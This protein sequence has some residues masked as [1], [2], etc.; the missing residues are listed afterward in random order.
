MSY[1]KDNP[2]AIEEIKNKDR[3][4]APFCFRIHCNTSFFLDPE[5]CIKNSD[6]GKDITTQK[7]FMT[8]KDVVIRHLQIF[9]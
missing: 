6:N 8:L 9:S 5:S 2:V 1:K 3:N 4:F 7:I